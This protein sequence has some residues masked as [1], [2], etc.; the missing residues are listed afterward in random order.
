[1]GGGLA[2]GKAVI[3]NGGGHGGRQAFCPL[4]F[5]NHGYARWTD[6]IRV[7]KYFNLETRDNITR[8]SGRIALQR[9]EPN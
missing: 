8:S 2:R 3:S 6:P 9:A 5:K 1:M 4:Q 7:K